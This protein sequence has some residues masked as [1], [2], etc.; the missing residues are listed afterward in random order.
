LDPV[1]RNPNVPRDGL[2]LTSGEHVSGLSV[3]IAEGAAKLSGHISTVLGQPL[4]PSVRIYLVPAEQEAAE[5]ILRFYE[6]RPEINGIFALDYIAPGK[7]W[8]VVRP[9]E[10]NNPGATKPV[11]QDAILRAKVF[12]EAEVQRKTVTLKPCEEVADFEIPAVAPA[13]P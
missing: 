3:T 2:T 9:V 1:A 13:S 6:A 8:I 11:R 12:R 7:Y 10:V 4:S 5:N